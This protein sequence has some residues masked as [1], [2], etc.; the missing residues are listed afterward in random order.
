MSNKPTRRS[1]GCHAL[2]PMLIVLPVSG[3]SHAAKSEAFGTYGIKSRKLAWGQSLLMGASNNSTLRPRS[4]SSMLCASS[5]TTNTRPINRFIAND[6]LQL[7]RR[8]Y[9]HVEPLRV[10]LFVE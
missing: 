10:A 1:L 8:G 9:E 3:A 7:F 2:D 4:S 5:S 6:K